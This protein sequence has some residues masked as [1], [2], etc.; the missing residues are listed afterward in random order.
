MHLN[1]SHTYYVVDVHSGLERTG[2]NCVVCDD[3]RLGAGD[4]QED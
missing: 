4:V 1:T 2:C 3:L